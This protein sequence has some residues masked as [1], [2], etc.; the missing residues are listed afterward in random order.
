M[1]LTQTRAA[2][3]DM[4]KTLAIVLAVLAPFVIYAGTARSIVAIWNSS[5]T[6]SCRS[7]S[8]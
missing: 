2:P 8:G 7:A 4:L 3:R 1:L 6:S 5:E